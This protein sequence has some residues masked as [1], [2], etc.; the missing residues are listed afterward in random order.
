MG[1]KN[2]INIDKLCLLNKDGEKTMSNIEIKDNEIILKGTT[3]K[4]DD[5][6]IKIKMEDIIHARNEYIKDNKEYVKKSMGDVLKIL[7]E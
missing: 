6:F 5:V 7:F 1:I 2:F 3:S 4:G